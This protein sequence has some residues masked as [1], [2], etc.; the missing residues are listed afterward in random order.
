MADSMQN[1]HMYEPEIFLLWGGIGRK[2]LH[3]D[4][5]TIAISSPGKVTLYPSS[6]D[7]VPIRRNK[8]MTNVI[9]PGLTKLFWT[10]H[11]DYYSL[12]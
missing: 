7:K 8:K 11:L 10:E 12:G 6:D 1:C 9:L 2:M 3:Q 4:P 5:K